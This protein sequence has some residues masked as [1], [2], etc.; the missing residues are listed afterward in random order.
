[1]CLQLAGPL[2]E[3]RAPGANEKEKVPLRAE[4]FQ[5]LEGNFEKLLLVD[6]MRA[7]DL[8]ALDIMRSL[9]P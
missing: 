3:F 7:P 2:R 1:M 4:S 6:F 8:A 9:E 5:G